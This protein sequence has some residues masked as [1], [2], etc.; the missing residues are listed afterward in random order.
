MNRTF[1]SE[2]FWASGRVV[3]LCLLWL[4]TTAMSSGPCRLEQPSQPSSHMMVRILVGSCSEDDRTLLAVSAKEVLA[5]L[6]SGQGVELDGVRLHG[7][8]MLDALPLEPI[9]AIESFPAVVKERFENEQVTEVRIIRGPVIFRNVDVPGVMATN[10]VHRGYMMFQGPVSI[11]KST[12]HQS[13]DFSRAIFQQP[14][15]ASD[16]TI[17]V[18]AFFIKAMFLDEAHFSQTIFGTHTRFHRAV[19]VG[20]ADL[21]GVEFLG[22]AELLEVTFQGEVDFSHTRFTQGSGFSGSQFRKIPNFSEA[23]FEEGTFF[24]FSQFEQGANF[25]ESQFH[26]TADFTDATFGGASD[27]SRVVFKE[28]PQFT[29]ESLKDQFRQK[30]RQQDPRELVG[31]FVLAGIILVFFY[32][33]FR[34]HERKQLK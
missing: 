18:E 7:D 29:E 5:A 16:L 13:V 1:L 31:V 3:A 10:L 28:A 20:P 30:T 27:F 8:L 15:D 34:R 6:Q 12:F 32:F 23:I 9:P 24:R 11:T 22:L 19:F 14:V 17:A 2:S 33:L 25:R 26:K 21:Q 4:L